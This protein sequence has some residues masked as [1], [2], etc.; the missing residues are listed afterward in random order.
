[1]R[2]SFKRLRWPRATKKHGHAGDQEDDTDSQRGDRHTAQDCDA[3]RDK[4]D[5]QQ[6]AG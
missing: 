4:A 3:N 5:E 2:M 1:M 6:N